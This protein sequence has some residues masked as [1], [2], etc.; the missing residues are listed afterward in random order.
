MAQ[1]NTTPNDYEL[2]G[3]GTHVTYT[4]SSINGQPQFHYKDAVYDLNFSGDQIM[5]MDGNIGIAVT[6]TLK[7]SVDADFTTFT[8]MLPHINLAG[9]ESHFSALGILTQHHFLAS[10]PNLITGPHESYHA[11]T[12]HGTARSVQF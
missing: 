1:Q 11:V 12:L 10:N 3:H 7:R 5:A 9:S 8:L 2:A 4:T 6:V